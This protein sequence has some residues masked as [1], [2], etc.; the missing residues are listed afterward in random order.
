[1]FPTLFAKNIKNY[2]FEEYT[3]MSRRGKRLCLEVESEIDL[4]KVKK[5]MKV[6]YNYP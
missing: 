5:P 1:M 3:T 6:Y 2:Y 4:T